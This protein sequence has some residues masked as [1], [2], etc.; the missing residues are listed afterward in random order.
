MKIGPI[1]ASRI[2]AMAAQ[3]KAAAARPASALLATQSPLVSRPSEGV[4]VSFSSSLK[5]MLDQVNQQ[6]LNADQLA[7]RFALGDDRVNLSDVM[8]E[9]QKASLSLQATVQV[10]NKLVS[11]YQEIMNMAV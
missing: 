11:A 3:M 10:R 1:D 8:V 5:S 4:K 9:R 6:Q 2:E 7:Q